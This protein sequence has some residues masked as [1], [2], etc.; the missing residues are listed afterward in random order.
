MVNIWAGETELEISVHWV[1]ISGPPKLKIKG[2]K[3]EWQNLNIY[4]PK[5]T[6][7]HQ[8]IL[9]T[10]SWTY[11]ATAWHPDSPASPRC[12]SPGPAGPGGRAWGPRPAQGPAATGRRQWWGSWRSRCQAAARNLPLAL[13]KFYGI[14]LSKIGISGWSSQQKYAKMG[15]TVLKLMSV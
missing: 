7:N 11:Q 14:D 3:N 13:G 10:S 9:E 2:C 6:R 5:K 8:Y 15:T 1:L 12:T 4:T